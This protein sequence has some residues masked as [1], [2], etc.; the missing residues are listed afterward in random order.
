MKRVIF[1]IFA[2]STYVVVSA[3]LKA[4]KITYEKE[5]K[6]QV[7]MMLGSDPELKK[8]IPKSRKENLELLFGNNQA[9]LQVLPDAT[10]DAMQLSGEATGFKFLKSSTG[11]DESSY[12]DLSKGKKI[13][14]TELNSKRYVIEDTLAR[15]DWK[16]TQESKTILGYNCLKATTATKVKTNVTTMENGVVKNSEVENAIE[17]VVWFTKEIP[18][19]AGPAYQGQL[20]GMILGADVNNGRVVYK[21]V[22]I[23]PKVNLANIKEPKGGKRIARPEFQK[24]QTKAM[25]D[26]TK[27]LMENMGKQIQVRQ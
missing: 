22:E 14:E 10:Q 6:L 17:I 19:A 9:L 27:Y 11:D 4:G 16:I 24:M 7:T 15:F 25:E 18:V 26:R 3:Q 13:S 12:F 5:F 20:P 23:S 8:Q 2:L 1:L 21:A